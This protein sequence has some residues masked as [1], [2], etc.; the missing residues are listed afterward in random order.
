MEEWSKNKGLLIPS[1][2]NTKSEIPQSLQYILAYRCDDYNSPILSIA[3]P[4]TE[5]HMMRS[6]DCVD[7][8]KNISTT[9]TSLQMTTALLMVLQSVGSQPHHPPPSQTPILLR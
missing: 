7:T 2:R 3:C 8:L 5:Q 9:S 1:S 6:I 4:G